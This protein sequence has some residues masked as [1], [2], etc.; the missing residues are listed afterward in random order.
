[1]IFGRF[2]AGAR[3]CDVIEERKD[4]IEVLLANRVVLVIVA[5]CAAKG[6]P[7]PNGTGGF[8]AVNDGFDT[9]LFCDDAAFGID[10]VIA[11]EAGGDDLFSRG[12]WEHVA[13]ELL[14]GELVKGF[15]GVKG[16][17]HPV[18]PAVL[19]AFVVCL[20]AI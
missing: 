14:D 11:V 10:T 15:V 20:I 17:D 4:G 7:K 5:A 9:P 12:I 18:A 13:S 6:H 16:I 1:M 3:L 2:D 8:D 19:K